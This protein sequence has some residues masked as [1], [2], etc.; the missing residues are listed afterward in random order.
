[1][2]NNAS[3]EVKKGEFVALSGISGAGKSTIMRLLL[4]LVEPDC[5]SIYLKDKM[6]TD[7]DASTRVLFGY[8]PQGN[9]LISGTIADNIAFY[10]DASEAEIK[11]AAKIAQL[12]FAFDLP[13]GLDT[14][15]GEKGA[16]L[17][18]GQI[19]RIAIARALVRKSP[20][21][22][23]D[24]ATSALDEDTEIKILDALKKDKDTTVIIITHR[25]R[26]FDYCDKIITLFE[27]ELI[28]EKQTD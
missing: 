14:P 6:N 21:L 18:E 19:Q 16:G 11:K 24:E 13:E 28:T 2:L 26:V 27:G 22:L 8:V 20:V 23:L 5:G 7:I 15:L 9:L 25:K 4:S 17:S 3:M 1:M 12:D 10:S